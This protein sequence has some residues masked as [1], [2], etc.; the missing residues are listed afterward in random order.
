MSLAFNSFNFFG[1]N[2]PHRYIQ[3]F[4]GIGMETLP[5]L[6]HLSNYLIPEFEMRSNQFYMDQT[7]WNKH[8]DMNVFDAIYT[9]SYLNAHLINFDLVQIP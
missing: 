6:A 8:Y 4:N 9:N 1:W 2:C 3:H 5:Y 7:A